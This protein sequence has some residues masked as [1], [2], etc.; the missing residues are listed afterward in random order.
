MDDIIVMIDKGLPIV[1]VAALMQHD[2]QG[3]MLHA[4][5]PITSISEMDGK[6]VMIGPGTVMVKLMEQKYGL[7]IKV[8]P[9][10]FGI[11]RFMV[12][13]EFIQQ[14]FVTS[15]PYFVRKNGG[16]AKVIL[17]SEMG[18]DPYRVIFTRR[19]MTEKK[20]EV[21]SAFVEASIKGWTDYLDPAADITAANSIIESENEIMDDPEFIKYTLGVMRDYQ[22]VAGDPE[23][24]EALGL[25]R[26]DRIQAGIDMLQDF[27]LISKVTDAEEV[28]TTEFLPDSLKAILAADAE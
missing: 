26:R 15:E 9:L 20:P 6:S 5:N 11:G 21:V 27:K 24:N 22:L 4:D 3:L 13:P 16:E 14:C 17:I 18:H 23:K 1:I 10:D 8:Q 2:P 28:F 7:S 25:L 12:D 19:E